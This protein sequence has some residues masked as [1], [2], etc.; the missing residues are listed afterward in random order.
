[1]KRESFVL[2]GKKNQKTKKDSTF[3]KSVVFVRLFSQLNW[4]LKLSKHRATNY[5]LLLLITT[6]LL[7]DIKNANHQNRRRKNVF[8][9]RHL[10]SEIAIFRTQIHRGN[11][12][13]HHPIF[14]FIT[15]EVEQQ[16]KELS[17]RRQSGRW[18]RRW[19]RGSGFRERFDETAW[20]VG[21]RAGVVRTSSRFSQRVWGFRG[22]NWLRV[23]DCHVCLFLLNFRVDW[24][25]GPVGLFNVRRLERIHVLASDAV[26]E[27][28]CEL[29]DGWFFFFFCW[30]RFFWIIIYYYI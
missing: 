11:T 28:D 29:G 13:N 30:R 24:F 12:K 25:A 1:M 4:I 21:G 17:A 27:R 19:V 23:D 14:F 10:C 8:L 5:T 22:W 3:S 7:F 18:R 15:K 26:L 2:I 9:F 20:R 16:Q 6:L